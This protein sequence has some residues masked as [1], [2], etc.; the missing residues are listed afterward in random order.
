[1]Y[2]IGLLKDH[3]YISFPKLVCQTNET[4]SNFKVI[5][6]YFSGKVKALAGE[7]A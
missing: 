7:G 5:L 6:H 3:N 4:F 1:M 2:V